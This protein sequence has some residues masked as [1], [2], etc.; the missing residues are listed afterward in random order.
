VFS[1]K[2]PTAPS[3]PSRESNTEPLAPN[4]SATNGYPLAKP[5]Y[6]MPMHT[7]VSP[8]QSPLLGTLPALDIVVPSASHLG[9]SD[10]TQA[11]AYITQ[12]AP[13]TTDHLGVPLDRSIRSRTVWICHR[14]SSVFHWTVRPARIRAQTNQVTPHMAG[15]S[16]FNLRH[17]GQVADRPDPHT[18][19]FGYG[20]T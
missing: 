11:R 18:G 13:Y 4:T 7:F 9:Q 5:T 1:Y 15:L 20:T 3:F 16:G 8:S 6:G 19:P 17:F 14:S 2:K 10:P 12:V